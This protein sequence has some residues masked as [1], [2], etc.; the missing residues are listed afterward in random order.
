ML[1]TQATLFL[2][3]LEANPLLFSI[4]KAYLLSM[5]SPFLQP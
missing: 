5:V 3:V 2:A 1:P 4:S